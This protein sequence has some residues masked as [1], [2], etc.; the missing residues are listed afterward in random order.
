MNPIL[1]GKKAIVTGGTSGIGKA[2]ALLFALHGAQVALFGTNAERG[3]QTIQEIQRQ[4]GEIPQPL[5]FQVDV[6]KTDDVEKAIVK[7]IEQLGQIDILVNN[8]GVTADQL[9]MRMKEEEWDRV[10]TINAK[11]CYNTCRV[12]VRPMMKAKKGK[13]INVSSVI[14]MTGNPGQTNYA[15]S[16]AAVIG[17]TKALAKEVA[18]RQICVNC[19]APGYIDTPMTQGLTAEQKDATLEK[20]PLGRMGSP[21]DIAQVALFLASEGADYITGQV[22]PV[23]G[24]MV[25]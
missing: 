19:I 16:K 10:M 13:I 9:I 20:I 23:D 7:V 17:F 18:T 24:G 6:A 21:S 1:K 2:I 14:G 25:I 12:V 8:A 15:A 4:Q 3:E 5:F 11:S 22:L